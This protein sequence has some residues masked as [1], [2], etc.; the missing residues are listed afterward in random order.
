MW[1]V[2]SHATTRRTSG[3]HRQPCIE[4]LEPRLALTWAG[5]PPAS[6]TPPSAALAVS[7]N[8][9]NDATGSASIATTEVDYYSFGATVSGAYVISATTPTSSVDTVLGVFSASG[10]RLTYNDDISSTNRD[11]RV[12]TNLVAGTRY[13][14]GITNYTSS[15]RGAYTWTIDGPATALADDSY[16]NNDSQATAANLGTLTATT[17]LSQLVMADSQDWFRFTT[18]AAGTS[19]NSVSISFQNSAGNLQL[20]LYNSSGTLV[21][22]S[23]GTGNSETISLNGLA[24]GTYSV[25]VYGNGGALNPS[26]SLSINPPPAGTTTTPVTAFPNV[27]Y[28]GGSNEWNLNAINAPEAWRKDT[29]APG[30]WWRLSIPA[31]T[32]ITPN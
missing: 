18:V 13:Y 3:R 8:S 22:S 24:A 14:I 20:A 19:A 7:L 10:Q 23:L 5:V 29:P 15:S 17:T 2:R 11:S 6:I 27:P 21:G 4:L 32:W 31:S 28:Y 25:L 16:E 1:L 26:Y 12:T 9:Q 30:W